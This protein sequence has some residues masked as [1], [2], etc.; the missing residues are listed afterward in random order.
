MKELTLKIINCVNNYS[1]EFYDYLYSL[2]G[3]EDVII[4]S[5]DDFTTIYTKYDEMIINDE[6]IKYEILTF[7]DLNNQP[8]I[9]SFDRHSKEKL[10]CKTKV[11]NDCC[12]FCYGNIIYPLFDIKGIEKV[13][14][15]FYDVYMKSSGKDNYTLKVYYDPKL[16]S[17][18]K[19]EKIEKEID[20]YS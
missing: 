15:D 1:N 6:I 7:L 12:D 17:K 16:I 5:D 9:V 14:S 13:E 20:I 4:I 10:V 2:N 18:E 8:V 11:C 3:V 19:W